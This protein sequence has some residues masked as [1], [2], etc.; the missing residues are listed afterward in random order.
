MQSTLGLLL[1]WNGRLLL[2]GRWRKHGA[3]LPMGWAGDG[4][5]ADPVC[6]RT[7][8]VGLSVGQHTVFQG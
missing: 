6:D 7:E 5:G 8:G 1:P 2:L 3:A 4:V